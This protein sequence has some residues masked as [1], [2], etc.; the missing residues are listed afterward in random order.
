MALV[1]QTF[2]LLLE[3]WTGLRTVQAD[4]LAEGCGSLAD[5]DGEIAL[6]VVSVDTPDGPDAG[7]IEG[8]RNLGLPVLAFGLEEST[9]PL[10]RALDAGADE[11]ISLGAPVSHL[12]GKARQLASSSALQHFS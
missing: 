5:L 6:A 10:A 11:A 3:W 7:L 8:L 2:A 12:I 1:R 4:S 9:R